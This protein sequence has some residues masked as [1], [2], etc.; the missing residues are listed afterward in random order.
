MK[1]S[2]VAFITIGILFINCQPM[3]SLNE[4][5][6]NEI[7]LTYQRTACFGFCPVYEVTL[8]RDG[9][10]YFVGKQ[11]VPFM[12]T[13]ELRMPEKKMNQIKAILTHPDYLD[14]TI[15]EPNEQITD[16]P[17]L[18]FNDYI[19][20][21]QYE[22]DMII[23]DPITIIT[24]KIDDVL[25]SNK[26]LYHKKEYPMVRRE[27]LVSLKPGLDPYSLDGKETFYQLAFREN[28]GNNVYKYEII[29]PEDEINKALESIKQRQGVRETQ[30]VHELD[31]R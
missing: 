13:L 3:K 16:I 28:I 26:L 20:D 31:R 4:V 23:P 19:N 11:F 7:L 21:R 12:D 14:M 6:K 24:S 29:C 2:F 15:D 8:L 22:L 25:E 5:Q 30:L 9:R 27:I 1:N 10:A 17:G 18:H